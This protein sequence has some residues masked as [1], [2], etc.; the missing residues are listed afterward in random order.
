ATPVR[1]FCVAYR[2]IKSGK[3][4][5]LHKFLRSGQSIQQARFS[6]VGVPRDR[7][8][9]NLPAPS[10]RSLRSSSWRKTGDLLPQ[11]RHAGADLSPIQLDLRLTGAARA[12]TCPRRTDLATSL[13]RHRLTPAA[14]PRQEVLQ[15]SEF[16]LGF[17][18]AALCMLAEDIENYGGAIHHFD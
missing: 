16:Y 6:G 8:R 11:F 15:L 12:H 5:V 7:D 3:Q 2:G 14:K 1:C 4:L 13:P 17:A 18:L 10:V 9:G